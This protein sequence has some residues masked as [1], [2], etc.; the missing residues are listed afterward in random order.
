MKHNIDVAIQSTMS[1]GLIV[2]VSFAQITKLKRVSHVEKI[3]VFCI[4]EQTHDPV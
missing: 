1:Q 2:V 3:E 4:T